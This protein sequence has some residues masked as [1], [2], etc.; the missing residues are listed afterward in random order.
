MYETPILIIYICDFFML[1]LMNSEQ[2]S[3]L[4]HLNSLEQ[5]IRNPWK[6][7]DLQ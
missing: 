3:L 1:Q 2:P 6:P 5:T 7:I 4:Q